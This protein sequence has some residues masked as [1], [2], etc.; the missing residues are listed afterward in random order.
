MTAFLALTHTNQ[1][2]VFTDLPNYIIKH[3]LSPSDKLNIMYADAFYDVADSEREAADIAVASAMQIKA[4]KAPPK[5][6]KVFLSNN[7]SF[8]CAYCGCR[9]THDKEKYCFAPKELAQISVDA[10]KRTGQG[11]FVTSAVYKNADYTQELIIETVKSIRNDCGYLG[12]LHAK[13]MP[14]ADPAL[15][16]ETGLFANRLSVNIEVARS[17][18]Y[19]MIARQKNKSNILAPMR[20]ISDYIAGARAERAKF[21]A[22]QTTQLMAGSTGEDDRTILTLSSAMYKK[23]R[24]KRVYYTPFKYEHPAIGYDNLS[25]VRTPQWRMRRLY[26]AD[27]LMELYGFAPEEITPPEYTYLE[28]DLDPKAAW[29]LRH[30]DIY[31]VELNTAGYETLL[32]IPGIGTTFAKRIIEARKICGLTFETVKRMRVP[33]DKSGKFFTCGGLYMGGL[34]DNVRAMRAALADPAES[35]GVEQLSLDV[36]GEGFC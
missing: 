9:C 15:I 18:G 14:G 29:A 17:E 11:I 8:N 28:Q 31:P 32:R 3:E 26:Q 33:M 22:S 34:T 12:Y 24:L 25:A 35:A 10:A 6:P 20:Q 30:L 1:G 4:A 5:V 13:V 23:Y 7:C 36:V 27:R 21:A 16:R 19:Q 2:R